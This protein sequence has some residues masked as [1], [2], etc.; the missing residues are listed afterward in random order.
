MKTELER[1]CR[2]VSG[3]AAS[4]AAALALAV[5]MLSGAG[6]QAANGTIANARIRYIIPS[7]PA[8]GYFTY[9][10]TTGRTQ[11]L[12]AASSPNCGTLMLHK[13]IQVNGVEEMRMVKEIPIKPHGTLKFAPGG[14]HLMCMKP[15]L[16]VG[17]MVP[18]TLNFSDGKSMTAPFKVGNAM[19]Q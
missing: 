9:H 7:R 1:W 11:R 5:L 8:A 4:L 18:V 15:K 3:R 19:T 14:Y 13:S 16:K 2:P 12:V 6:A 17:A 10:N